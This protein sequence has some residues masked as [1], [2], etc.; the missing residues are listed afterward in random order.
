MTQNAIE[1]VNLYKDA[2]DKLFV[3]LTDARASEKYLMESRKLEGDLYGAAIADTRSGAFHEAKHMLY[4]AV[5]E[6]K[7]E[8]EYLKQFNVGDTV[9]LK[10]GVSCKRGPCMKAKIVK[11]VTI[12]GDPYAFVDRPIFGDCYMDL[13]DLEVC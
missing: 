8:T 10:L 13:K 11:F 4:E 6:V 2:W 12:S 3:K 7:E 9:R 1:L 5:R